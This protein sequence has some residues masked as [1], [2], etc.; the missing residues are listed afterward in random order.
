MAAELQQ[1]ARRGLSRRDMIK[2]SAAAGAAA[3]TAPVIIDSLASPAAAASPSCTG[4]S[5]T[6][7]WIYILFQVPAGG[8]FVTGFSTGD[9]ACNSGGK[10][11]GGTRCKANAG[12]EWTA[13]PKATGYTI[14]LHNFSSTP[15]SPA[16]NDITYTASGGCGGTQLNTWTFM[17]AAAGCG[18]WI[19]FNGGQISAINGATILAAMGFGGGALIP[20][21]TSSAGPNNSVCGIEG[22]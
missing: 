6:M 10:N 3:W 17:N 21:C 9:K 2:A 22:V 11:N 16:A 18:S 13:G 20:A 1:G 15:P 14:T 12:T 8:I 7:S 5:V 19:Q 4:T